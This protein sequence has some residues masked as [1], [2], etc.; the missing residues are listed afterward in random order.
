[1]GGLRCFEETICLSPAFAGLGFPTKST[2]GFCQDSRLAR[3]RHRVART[4]AEGGFGTR[5]EGALSDWEPAGD[6]TQAGIKAGFGADL[7]RWPNP[8]IELAVAE[9]RSFKARIQPSRESSTAA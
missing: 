5:G 3:E 8:G 7:N 6:V 1:M 2:A 9:T 4:T